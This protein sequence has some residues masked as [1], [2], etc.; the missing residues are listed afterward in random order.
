MQE[1]AFALAI[2][3]DLEFDVVLL[4]KKGVQSPNSFSLH[5]RFVQLC[6]GVT[7]TLQNLLV[8]ELKFAN[9]GHKLGDQRG[10]ANWER[11]G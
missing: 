7:L 4:I 11:N 10:L 2:F 3:D 9:L 8:C 1:L 6:R 5:L